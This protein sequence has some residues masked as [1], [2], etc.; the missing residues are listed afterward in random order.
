MKSPS[1]PPPTRGR[2]RTAASAV[3]CCATLVLG[4]PTIA[5]GRQAAPSAVRPTLEALLFRFPAATAAER[6]A[7]AAQLAGLG[8]KAVA[9]LCARLV[10]AG[11]ADDAA[12]RF[13]LDALAV[14]AARPGADDERKAL[15]KQLAEA[16]KAAPN[17]EAKAFLIEM[18]RR[19]GG[20]EAVRRLADCLKDPRMAD[21]AA[22]AL[23]SIGGEDAER[24]LLRELDGAPRETKPALIQAL[25]RMRSRRAVPALIPY[26][27]G[28]DEALRLA[29]LE[30]LAWSGDPAAA[31]AFERIRLLA[32]AA[33]RMTVPSL[34]LTFG[35]RLFE[36]GERE[37]ALEIGRGVIRSFVQPSES[38][39]RCQGLS[40]LRDILGPGVV[41][42]LL[43]AIDSGDKDYRVHALALA[44]ALPGPEAVELWTAKLDGA[45]PEVRA[46]IIDMLGRRGEP[47]GLHAVRAGLGAE[48][49][50]VRLAS[51]S[52]LRRLAG[53]DA[54]Q[55][56]V[57]ALSGGVPE[58]I[59]AVKDALLAAPA[60]RA[61]AEASRLLDES[62]PA[63]KVAL[64]EVLAARNARGQADS[65]F[66]LVRAEPPELGRAALLALE[67]VARPSDVPRLLD[68]LLESEDAS[69]TAPLQ[70]A[71]AAAS[72][73]VPDPE[74]RA[75]PI[76]A[77]LAY[78]APAKRAD[79]LR[80]LPRI[81]G[82][83]ALG[84]VT[85][86]TRSADL[87]VQAVA[88]YALSQWPEAFALDPLLEVL[89][90]N[91]DP[92]ARNLALQGIARLTRDSELEPEDRRRVV[93]DAWAQNLQTGEKKLLLPA[94]GE[95]RTPGALALAAAALDDPELRDL[96]ADAVLAAALPR[97]GVE[98]LEGIDA[99]VA[100]KKA[101]P[102]L[103]IAFDVE[104]AEAHAAAIL[105]KEGF[106]PLFDG[107]TLAGWKG[108]VADP[109]ARAKM[110]ADELSKAQAAADEDMRRHW[111]AVDGTLSFDGQGH[112]LCT[113]RD[114]GDFEL[115]VDWK[116]EPQGDS[117]I[118]LRGSPQVQIWDP[119][120]WPEGSGGL[121]NNQVNP[122]KPLRPAD[123]PVG[124]WNTFRIR[125]KGERVTVWLNGALV[126]DD[127]VMENYWEREKPIDPAGQ[128]ELQAHS[129][130]LAF[131]NLFIRE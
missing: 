37:A 35:R 5:S 124:T 83:K 58:E 3:L 24:A 120:R 47:A 75:D 17:V 38:Q 80:V 46:E 107:R 20:H 125:M 2:L 34:L 40:L 77:A 7:L 126:V 11:E 95:V 61:V 105:A 44:A 33:E 89:K 56:L 60:A 106:V 26:A 86:E 57:P 39:L 31:A 84:A 1:D 68:L 74:R 67:G 16:L 29:A 104:R 23:A 101:A 82:T 85:A 22:G 62:P 122:A 92:K 30:A 98:G 54:I 115:F 111:R 19:T 94:L 41:G 93:L 53:D 49:P 36:N 96:A 51:M 59:A 52:A 13:A 14:R 97:T 87:L 64:L 100:L 118:Y 27:G 15:V 21:A 110:S 43:E 42:V 90:T 69:E 121:Y 66:A 25:G 65:I 123:N 128:I 45:A 63:A 113:A 76:L 72:L 129:T 109:P 18:T 131:K 127:V 12:V 73:R 71:L 114:Y 103:D 116:I 108:L 28:R 6:D 130:P 91:P 9:A 119:A 88:V 50:A 117:G 81:G 112:S 78:S 55:E 48:E 8:P 10:P 70:N 79:L 32:P 102:F 99:A 4:A